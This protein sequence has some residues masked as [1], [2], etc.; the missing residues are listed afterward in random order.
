MKRV[1]QK[2]IIWIILQVVITLALPNHGW[3]ASPTGD[4]LAKHDMVQK[5]VLNGR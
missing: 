1:I 5:V 2:R 3:G 4:F